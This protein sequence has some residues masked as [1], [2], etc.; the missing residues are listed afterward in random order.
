AAAKEQLKI[1]AERNQVD[2]I[3]QSGN[4]PSAVIYDAVTA[5]QARQ[6]DIVLADTAGRLPTQ[7]HLMDEIRKIKRVIDKAQTNAPHE[8]LLVLDASTGQNAINQVKAFHQALNL[9]GLV[10]TKLDGSARGGVLLAIAQE[11]PVP[12]KYIGVGENVTDLKKFD[13]QEFIAALLD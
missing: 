9:T 5:A 2:I 10:L 3:S 8:I 4:D 6:I 7:T 1:W 13:A 11:C 12:I